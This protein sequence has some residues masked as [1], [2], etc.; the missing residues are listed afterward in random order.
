MELAEARASTRFADARARLTVE[1]AACWIEAGGAY[2]VYDGPA[3]PLTQ[4]FGLG[5]RQ[6]ATAADL[7]RIEAFFRT[8]GAPV[9]HEVSPLVD[10]ATIALLNDRGYRPC[11][12]TTVLYRPL[13]AGEPV[14]PNAAIRVRQIER[15]E[16]D[17]WARTAAAGW[18][19]FPDLGVFMAEAGRVN[20]LT[21]GTRL[22]LAELDGRAIATGAMSIS[23]GV[24][25]LAGASTI[26]SA[27]GQGAQLALLGSRLGC[28][29]AQGCDL[30]LMGASP[31]SLSQRNAERHGFR[32]AYTRVKWILR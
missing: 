18:S 6:P 27:R 25:H 15:S 2:A 21:E 32:V 1:T 13:P 29:A 11:E 14:G 12:F 7:D 9:Y 26:P 22:F 23:E 30:A 8:R 4:T 17:L 24:A 19:Q 20:A 28:A 5:I 10:A 16:A 31:G 3:S